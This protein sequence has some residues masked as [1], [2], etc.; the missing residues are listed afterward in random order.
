MDYK[1]KS[2]KNSKNEKWTKDLL[3]ETICVL[4]DNE[5][6]RV[7]DVVT[8][9]K[10][11]RVVKEIMKNYKGTLLYFY[12]KNKDKYNS[13]SDV[14]VKYQDKFSFEIYQ[15]DYIV[16]HVRCGDD[17]IKRGLTLENILILLKKLKEYD[18]NKK[19]ILVT[20]L[21]YGH[22]KGH[23]KFYKQKVYCYEEK[24]HDENIVRLQ[25]LVA[26]ISQEVV[27]IISNM[28]VDLD[29]LTLSFA[30]NLVASEKAGGF[31]LAVKKWNDEIKEKEQKE[32]TEQKIKDSNK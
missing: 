2:W 7:A 22:K 16:V 32:Q 15:G 25:Y 27:K 17:L 11:H 5:I 1:I 26:H 24:N 9:P 8:F 28:E 10:S 18:A 29:I 21:H 12:F 19:V 30:K 13:L 20:A 3:K 4:K 14:I 31:A 23:S 6:Y